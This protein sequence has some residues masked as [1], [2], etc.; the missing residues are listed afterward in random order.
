MYCII[1]YRVYK[2]G[3]EKSQYNN[4]EGGTIYCRPVHENALV[5]ASCT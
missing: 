5:L 1:I 4:L 2:I 3:V